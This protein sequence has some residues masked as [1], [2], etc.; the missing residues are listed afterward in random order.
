MGGPE[1]TAGRLKEGGSL[2]FLSADDGRESALS[3]ILLTLDEESYAVG[4]GRV[5]E[6]IRVPRITW[7]PGAPSHVSGVINLRGTIVPVIDL[8]VLLSLPAGEAGAKGRIVVVE[9][10]AMPV[11]LLVN[12]VE[13][14]AEVAPESVEPALRT[15]DD[16]Q[17]VCLEGQAEIGG[18]IVGILDIDRVMDKARPGTDT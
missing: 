4:I 5:K 17:R 11:G 8:A 7:V 1:Q 13:G 18:K 14:V 12:S 9:S 10:D 6:I 3:F 15:L 16:S 2:L